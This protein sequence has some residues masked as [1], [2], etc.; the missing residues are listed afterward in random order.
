MRE[1]LFDPSML[2]AF[3][4]LLTKI[5]KKKEGSPFD[6]YLGYYLFRFVKYIITICIGI[7]VYGT[8]YGLVYGFKKIYDQWQNGVSQTYK[9]EFLISGVF[10]VVLLVFFLFRKLLL[11][12]EKK[13]S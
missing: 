4:G 6:T 7:S 10:F 3:K 12:Y 9:I 5:Q 13:D 1:N 11:K 8:I 2:D